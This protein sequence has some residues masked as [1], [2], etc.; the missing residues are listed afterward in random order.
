[1]A[2]DPASPPAGIV[3]NVAGTQ[4]SFTQAALN[5]INATWLPATSTKRALIFQSAGDQNASTPY[6]NA[7]K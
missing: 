2:I 5:D 7:T 6:I 3:V 1:M 4:I